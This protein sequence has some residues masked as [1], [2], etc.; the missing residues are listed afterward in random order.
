MSR[1]VACPEPS[2]WTRASASRSI[3]VS[4]S[5]GSSLR[6]IDRAF[7][8]ESLPSK[9]AILS[10]VL[11]SGRFPRCRTETP[12]DFFTKPLGAMFERGFQLELH[13]PLGNP[14]TLGD[15]PERG[16]LQAG[17][18]QDRPAARRQL[19]EHLLEARNLLARFDLPLRP[20][21]R[22]IGRASC[23]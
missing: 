8:S 5:G 22:E 3:A 15:F 17:C 4:S 14:K 20:G 23:R 6:V 13:Q 21:R 10:D 1:R 11:T 9:C 19:L 7:L 16:T 18:Q 2:R 12:R